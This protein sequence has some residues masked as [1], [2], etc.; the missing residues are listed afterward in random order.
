MAFSLV[1]EHDGLLSEAG[2]GPGFLPGEVI[3]SLSLLCHREAFPTDES[4][5]EFGR[6]S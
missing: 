4:L 3:S 2:R 6:R 1:A 5:W